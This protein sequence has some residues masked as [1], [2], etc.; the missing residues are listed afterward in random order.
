MCSVET[1][2]QKHKDKQANKLKEIP[3]LLFAVFWDLC[4]LS[5]TYGLA[6]LSVPRNQPL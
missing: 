6:T 1:L 3:I 4:T 2:S 5:R